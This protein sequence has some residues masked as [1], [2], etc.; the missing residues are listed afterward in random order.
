ML[1]YPALCRQAQP[2]TGL[3]LATLGMEGGHASKESLTAL[4]YML[5]LYAIFPHISEKL[6]KDP[7]SLSPISRSLACSRLPRNP[8]EAVQDFN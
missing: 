7:P 5:Q 2:R 4:C 3:K 1:M 6:P 8:R